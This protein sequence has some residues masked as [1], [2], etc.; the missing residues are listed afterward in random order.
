MGQTKA[1]KGK[2]TMP[3]LQGLGTSRI[4][5]DEAHRGA[6]YRIKSDI[7][8]SVIVLVAIALVFHHPTDNVLA[9]VTIIPGTDDDID[10]GNGNGSDEIDE[11]AI[12]EEESSSSEE[13]ATVPFQSSFA[14]T[15][16]GNAKITQS[17]NYSHFIPL[18]NSPGDQLKVIVDYLVTDQSTVGESVNAVMEMFS[19]SN[20]SLIKISSFPNPII[21]NA[22]G[23]VQ[24][25][26]TFPDNSVTDVISLITFTDAEKEMALSDPL[27]L[28]LK[29][30]QSLPTS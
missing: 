8:I 6:D 25:A 29:L 7:C 5:V 3:R 22:S 23:T 28:T 19:V 16:T 14:D 21:A 18:T 27:T 13:V 20:Q 2:I 26:T 1:R 12:E 30:G 9:Q 15:L 17:V 24:L 11:E 4:V 10:D